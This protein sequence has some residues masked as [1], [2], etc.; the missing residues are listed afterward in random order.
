VQACWSQHACTPP[1]S[2]LV[3]ICKVLQIN[4]YS[5]RRGVLVQFFSRIHALLKENAERNPV[6]VPPEHVITWTQKMNGVLVD[7]NRRFFIAIDGNNLAGIFFYRY[8]GDRI[9]IEDVQTAWAYRNN[10]NVIE[11]FL[12][13]LEYDQGTKSATFYASER[14]NLDADKELL[15]TKGFKDTHEGGFEKLGTLSQAAGALRLRYNRS[16]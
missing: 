2:H 15:A 13:K 7:V 6:L 11:G 14:V 5:G 4:D 12:K 9:L 8:D 10:P 3:V 1:F 16:V